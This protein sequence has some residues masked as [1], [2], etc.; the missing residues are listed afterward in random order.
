M[1]GGCHFSGLLGSLFFAQTLLREMAC[2][3]RTSALHGQAL[4]C[5]LLL[6]ALVLITL[7]QFSVQTPA[8]SSTECGVF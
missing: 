8:F 7:R 5:S 1:V 4:S 6:A 3:P 2:N